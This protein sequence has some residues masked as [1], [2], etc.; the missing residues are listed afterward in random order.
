MEQGQE[1]LVM[2][3][4]SVTIL[5]SQS[6]FYVSYLKMQNESTQIVNVSCLVIYSYTCVR[7]H[8]SSDR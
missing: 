3:R 8:K 5:F 4:F 2:A 6:D 7:C 1:R